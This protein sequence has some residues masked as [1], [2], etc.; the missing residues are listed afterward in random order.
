MTEGGGAKLST[1]YRD[2]NGRA[3]KGRA[4]RVFFGTKGTHVFETF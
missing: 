2:T 3:G 4:R 1:T